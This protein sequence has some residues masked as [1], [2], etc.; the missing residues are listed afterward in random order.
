MADRS[1]VLELRL[2]LTVADFD[3]AVA[4]YRDGLGLPEVESWDHPDGRGAILAAGRATLELLSLDQAATIDAVEVGERVAG[5]VRIALEVEDSRATAAR[6]VDQGATALGDPVITPWQHRNVR[7][8]APDGMQ[9]TI[10]TIL[11]E[12]SADVLALAGRAVDL[13]LD[14]V[15]EGELPFGALV[16]RGGEV[17]ATGVNTANRDR[18]PTAHAETA[19]MRAALRATGGT[20]LAGATVVSSA[21]PCPA[22]H[23]TALMLGV[24][25]I[26]FAATRELAAGY[27]F[28]LPSAAAA[29]PRPPLV[30]TGSVV[31]VP[32]EAAD[33]P[34]RRYRERLS[35]R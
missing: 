33:A 5:P 11:G 16:V 1:P 32:F 6:L 28:V 14:N 34:F 9:L 26:V 35:A 13:A 4:F 7:L 18:D 20:D 24:E 2:A 17:L 25:R 29:I 23:A 31:G 30:G 19:A 12:D 3:R 27:G 21:E 8:S 22:C 15:D 10:Y